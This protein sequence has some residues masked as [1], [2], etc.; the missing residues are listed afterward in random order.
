MDNLQ[1]WSVRTIPINIPSPKLLV[2]ITPINGRS[3]QS[4]V[5]TI[6]ISRQSPKSVVRAFAISWPTSKSVI[7]AIPI[8]RQYPKSTVRK[9]PSNRKSPKL[10]VQT[11]PIRRESPKPIARTIQINCACWLCFVQCFLMIHIWT[12]GLDGIKTS[13]IQI[14]HAVGLSRP[15]MRMPWTVDQWTDYCSYSR[16]TKLCIGIVWASDTRGC[17]LELSGQVMPE[18]VYW[19]V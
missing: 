8:S 4:F 7:R 13:Y 1:K 19:F 2:P 16:V 3:P 11:M 10:I 15:F 12:Q 14:M 9:I 17:L 5:R 6:P 18:A